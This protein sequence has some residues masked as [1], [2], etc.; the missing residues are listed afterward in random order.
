LGKQIRYIELFCHILFNYGLMC[1]Y[2]G[3]L[4]T[5]IFQSILLLPNYNGINVNPT[6]IYS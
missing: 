6:L 2:L 5:L 3:L 4:N 1:H